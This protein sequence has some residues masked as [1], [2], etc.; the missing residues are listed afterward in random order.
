MDPCVRFVV[1]LVDNCMRQVS[2]ALFPSYASYQPPV[3]APVRDAV[4]WLIVRVRAS[5]SHGLRRP[6]GST[7]VHY[8]SYRIF[9]LSTDAV[10]QLLRTERSVFTS[11]DLGDF[12]WGD[13]FGVVLLARATWSRPI[14]LTVSVAR[15][16]WW[17]T[18]R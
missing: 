12:A 9:L 15:S 14:G 5:L 18:V 2:A 6:D 13:R 10:P 3:V 11:I 1:F 8:C 16:G 17:C 4:V 7:C